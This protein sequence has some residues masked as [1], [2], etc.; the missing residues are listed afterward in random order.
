MPVPVPVTKPNINNERFRGCVGQLAGGLF[1]P[2]KSA[3]CLLAYS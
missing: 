2:R 1:A 3:A